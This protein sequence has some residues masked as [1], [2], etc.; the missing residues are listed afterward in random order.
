MDARVFPEWFDNIVVP[1]IFTAP[2]V[3][4]QTPIDASP[5]LGLNNTLASYAAVSGIW[6]SFKLYRLGQGQGRSRSL[7]GVLL[8]IGMAHVVL[9]TV[10]YSRS[11]V[12]GGTGASGVDP[13]SVVPVV[14]I[15]VFTFVTAALCIGSGGADPSGSSGLDAGLRE[16][17]SSQADI[18]RRVETMAEELEP[19]DRV[20]ARIDELADLQKRMLATV[21]SIDQRQAMVSETEASSAVNRQIDL[22]MEEVRSDLEAVAGQVERL[23]LL[24]LRR[25]VTGNGRS[26]TP[27]YAS[28]DPDE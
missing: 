15:L 26:G 16:L 4:I 14:S 5:W 22:R 27:G 19:L 7:R 24:V 23:E 13:Y 8:A 3:M 1:A 25:L 20:E 2:A 9:G 21:S 28:G 18:A 17:T 12:F 11:G 10:V 6:M